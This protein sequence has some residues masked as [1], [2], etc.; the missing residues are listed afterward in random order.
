MYIYF[1]HSKRQATKNKSPV[2]QPSERC[3]GVFCCFQIHV[4]PSVSV[5]DFVQIN[6]EWLVYK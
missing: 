5:V 4:I 2:M 1:N 3:P 6:V